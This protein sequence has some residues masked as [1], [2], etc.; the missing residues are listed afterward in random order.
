V[1]TIEAAYLAGRVLLAGLCLAVA[2]AAIARTAPRTGTSRMLPR[3][4]AATLVLAALLSL[5]DAW[6]NVV[7]RR[8]EPIVL[9]SWAWLG[10]DLL[11]PVV[12]ALLLRAIAQRD[13]ALAGMAA[14][15]ET[16][17]LTGLRNRR[18]FLA[19]AE[20]ALARAVRHGERASVVMLDLDR[21][22]AINDAH[23]HAA[24]D[25]V[26][27]ATAEVL[28]SML[29]G[30]DLAGRLGGEEFALLLPGASAEVAAGAAERLRRALTARVPHPDARARVTASFGV[31]TVELRAAVPEAALEAAL[32]EA[33]AALYAAKR[34]GRDRIALAEAA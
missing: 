32:R 8:D 26:L 15:A 29:R 10:F 5:H 7:T 24:G 21:F 12:G 30:G 20:A 27:R 6:D 19:A 33:D 31:A 4:A 9:T 11:L 22:K 3:A 14:L 18:G 2:M 28:Q 16:D 1:P 17:A 13:E 34:G 23:G 25:A